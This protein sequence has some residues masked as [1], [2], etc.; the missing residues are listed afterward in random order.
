MQ[1]EGGPKLISVLENVKKSY[2]KENATVIVGYHTNYAVYVHENL[3]A[4]H[5]NGVAKFLEIPFRIY[6]S[7]MTKII[8]DMLS[9]TI[10]KDGKGSV[11]HWRALKK[12]GLFLQRESQ[13]LVPVDTG[14]LKGSARTYLEK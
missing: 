11:T 9:N 2:G 3:T 14:F 8:S 4:R 13:K 5:T 1:V 6:K 7:K 10:S 12:A